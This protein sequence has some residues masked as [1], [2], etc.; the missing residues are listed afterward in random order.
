MARGEI[1]AQLTDIHNMEVRA[2]VPL[3]HLPRTVAGGL[4]AV[5][6]SL[7]PGDRVAI[8]GA[9]NLNDGAAIK[10]M[11]SEATSATGRT[12]EGT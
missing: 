1:L 7:L 9:E 2:F 5:T 12:T 4:V 11:V 10:V 3:K 6:G 8:R